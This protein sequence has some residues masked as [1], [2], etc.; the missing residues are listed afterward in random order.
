MGLLD[1]E[2]EKCVFFER[3]LYMRICPEAPEKTVLDI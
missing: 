1:G 2:G 3:L